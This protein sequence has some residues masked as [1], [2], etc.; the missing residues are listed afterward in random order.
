MSHR[1]MAVARLRAGL[2]VL[3]ARIDSKR[4]AL[5][6]WKEFQNRLPTEDE[7]ATWFADSAAMCIVAGAVSGNLEMLDFEAGGTAFDAGADLVRSESP[8]LFER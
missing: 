4:P 3:P 8:D 7:I 1:D 2:C 5:A 6:G